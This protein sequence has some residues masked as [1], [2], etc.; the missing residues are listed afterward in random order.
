VFASTASSSPAPLAP[1]PSPIP[2]FASTS[3]VPPQLQHHANPMPIADGVPGVLK[4][5]FLTFDGAKDPLVWQNRCEQFFHVQR[6]TDCDRI[7]L[8]S[9]H[10]T[11]IAQ[12]WCYALDQDA[13]DVG[14]LTWDTFKALCRQRFGTPLSPHRLDELARQ[15]YHATVDEDQEAVPPRLASAG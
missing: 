11:G 9:F 14:A 15:S 7:W 12:Q 3:L 13:G 5:T 1:S 6:T 2:S 8:A 10:M 4:L